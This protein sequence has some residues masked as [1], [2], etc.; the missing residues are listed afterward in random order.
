VTEA[1]P[2]LTYVVGRLDRVLRRQIDESLRPYRLTTSQYTT[3][4]ILR[5][6]GALSNAQLARRALITPQSMSQILTGLEAKGLIA[7]EPDP[8]HGRILRVGL[9]AAGEKALEDCD[10]AIDEIEKR[11]LGELGGRERAELKA[12]LTACVRALGGG[13]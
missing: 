5:T 8:G 3:L 11:M 6:P 12:A 10:R 7:K 2:R 9:T 4:S 13:L 1:L